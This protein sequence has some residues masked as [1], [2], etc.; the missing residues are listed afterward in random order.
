ML[1]YW[2]VANE[3]IM[4]MLMDAPQKKLRLRGLPASLS[5]DRLSSADGL[6]RLRPRDSLEENGEAA[7]RGDTSGTGGV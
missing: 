6:L 2:R 4:G 5:A 3:V 1:I 7:S